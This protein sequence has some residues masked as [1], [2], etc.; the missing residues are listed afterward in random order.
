[1][2]SCSVAKIDAFWRSVR[3]TVSSG[4]SLDGKNCRDT[5]PSRISAATKAAIV[6]PMVTHF[7]RIAACRKLLYSS[8]SLLG[9]GSVSCFFGG[10]SSALPSSGPKTTATSQL[11]ISEIATTE[12]IEKVYSPAELSAKPIGTKAAI[13]T[14]VP[15]SIGAASVR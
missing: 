11:M 10:L 6:T 1:L 3:S 12:K 13:V 14:S 5:L 7:M 9:L 15:I 8:T 2:T 4:R